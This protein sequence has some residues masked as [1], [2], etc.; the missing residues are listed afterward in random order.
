VCACAAQL[1]ALVFC[2]LA[3]LA[4]LPDL[5]LLLLL[6]YD[7][8]LAPEMGGLAGVDAD[9]RQAITLRPEHGLLMTLQ[10]RSSMVA[11]PDK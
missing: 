7:C 8:R 11:Q 3:F 5:L 4:R 6:L 2:E 1:H 9:A 10:H